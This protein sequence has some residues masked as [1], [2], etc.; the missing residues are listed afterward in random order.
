MNNFTMNNHHILSAAIGGLLALGLTGNASAADS[1]NMEKCF[2][3]AKTGMNDC[4]SKKAGHSC[5]GQATKNSDPN[6][7]VAVPK[8]TCDKIAGG[9]A[10]MKEDS[11]MKDDGMMKKGM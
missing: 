4:G 11:M 3:I 6:D 9:T 5:A 10:M 8:G 7:F 1:K 2:G